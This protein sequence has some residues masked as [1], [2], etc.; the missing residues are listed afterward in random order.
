MSSFGFLFYSLKHTANEYDEIMSFLEKIGLT[1]FLGFGSFIVLAY[2]NSE[3]HIEYNEKI[4]SLEEEGYQFVTEIYRVPSE[5]VLAKF[6]DKESQLFLYENE[7]LNYSEINQINDI[8]K[9]KDF[10]CKNIK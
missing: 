10:F 6:C 8:H 5:N 4:S 2:N 1:A 9:K 3:E 7:E